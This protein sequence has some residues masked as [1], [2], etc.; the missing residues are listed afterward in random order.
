MQPITPSNAR[1]AIRLFRDAVNRIRLLQRTAIPRWEDGM[2][3]WFSDEPPSDSCEDA[4]TYDEHELAS[5]RD[6]RDLLLQSI[7]LNPYYPDAYLLVGNAFAEIDGD[8]DSMLQYYDRAIELDPNN[9]EFRNARMAHCLAV[10]N[11]R[12]RA[13]GTTRFRLCQVDARALRER[14]FVDVL[15]LPRQLNSLTT[16]TEKGRMTDEK[17]GVATAKRKTCLIQRASWWFRRFPVQSY[18]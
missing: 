9:D 18:Q 17:V 6:A 1:E 3:V 16:A 10:G 5:Y 15:R 4:F 7:E 11:H 13:L 2:P 14:G 8:L 12:F